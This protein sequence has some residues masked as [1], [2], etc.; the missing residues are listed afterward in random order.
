MSIQTTVV[1]SYPKP[2]PEGRPFT[3]R[4]TKHAI[5]RGEATP[6]DLERA[7]DEHTREV[8]AE[9][10]AAGIDIITDGHARWDDIL[11]PFARHMAGFQIGGL[12]RWFDNN[13]Y[14]RRP[15]CTGKIEWRGPATVDQFK[16]AQSVATKP[17]KAVLPG[18]VTFAHM[19]VDEHYADHE[20]FAMSIARVLAQEAFELEA[21]GATYIQ[22]DEPALLEHPEDLRLA[23]ECTYII[24][25][26]LK[27]AETILATYFGDAKRLGPELFDFSVATFGFDLISGPENAVLVKELPSEK[28]LQAG[29]VDARNTRL[30]TEED[31]ERSIIELGEIAGAESL[32]VSPSAGLEFLPREK[33]RAKLE[34]LANAAKKVGA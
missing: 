10:E 4:K 1:G 7:F 27:S 13:V 25:S 23:R 26:E 5:E 2:P 21:A 33:A 6:E 8:I 11:T 9:Q 16:F 14:Y 28:K 34:R 29:I 30:E 32:S 3:I 19:S 18:A 12:L 22:I 15:I 24:T 20:E 31:L 17:V